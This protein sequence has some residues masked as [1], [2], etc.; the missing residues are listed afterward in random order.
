[1]GIRIVVKD[2]DFSQSAVGYI[3][4][5]QDGLEYLNFFGG[6][7]PLGRNLAMN[8]PAAT[9]FGAPVVAQNSATFTQLVNFLQTSV[10]DSGS[11]TI[12]AV[13]RSPYPKGE[14]VLVSNY[15]STRAGAASTT[16]AS[17]LMFRANADPDPTEIAE[18]FIASAWDGST[19]ASMD[20][21]AAALV[22]RP[23]GEISCLVGRASGGSALAATKTRRI[24]NKTANLTLSSTFASKVFDLA[25]AFRIGSGYTGIT[26][27]APTE[28]FFAAIW[29]RDLTDE[30]VNAMY[31]AVKAYYAKRGIAV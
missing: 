23:L 15:N 9:V 25:Q 24:D 1:M 7:A 13:G 27:A 26:P 17:S 4:P 2:A 10:A 16:W 14:G 6:S 22:N 12:M 29:S 30:E 5:V 8:K 31:V 19:P 3:A 20:S 18:S 21:G 11:K 28:I